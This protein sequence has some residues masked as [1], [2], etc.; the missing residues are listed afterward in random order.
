MDNG[1]RQHAEF[2]SADNRA[3]EQGAVRPGM[4]TDFVSA[5]NIFAANNTTH[6]TPAIPIFPYRR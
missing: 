3:E 6:L 4:S 2:V 5:E 1:H